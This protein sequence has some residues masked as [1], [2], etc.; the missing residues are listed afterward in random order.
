MIEFLKFINKV[1][2]T[3]FIANPATGCTAKA[4]NNPDLQT[5]N[6]SLMNRP[7]KSEQLLFFLFKRYFIAAA[8]KNDIAGRNLMRV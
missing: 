3:K 5:F 4:G 1:I 8:C 7:A 2:S 6:Y